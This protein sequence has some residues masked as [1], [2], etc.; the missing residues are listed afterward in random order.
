MNA[1]DMEQKP[2]KGRIPLNAL[3]IPHATV[4]GTVTDLSRRWAKLAHV[5]HRISDMFTA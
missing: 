5:F 2:L 4:P 3:G 1:V